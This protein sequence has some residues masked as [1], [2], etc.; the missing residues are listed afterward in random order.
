MSAKRLGGFAAMLATV[1]GGVSL[2]ACS[3]AGTGSYF[4][5][6]VSGSIGG[7]NGVTALPTLTITA[8]NDSMV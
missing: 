6:S 8:S 7:V 4:T 1:A 5:D 2:L 3:V